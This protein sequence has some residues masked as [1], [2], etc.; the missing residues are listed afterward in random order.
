[1]KKQR[2]KGNTLRIAIDGVLAAMC[3]VLGYFALDLGSFKFTFENLPIII[4]ALLFGPVDGM[5]IGG[6]GTFVY[7]L[8]RYGLE[9]STPLWVVPYILSGLFVGLM[10]MAGKYKLK[11]VVMGIVIIA[12]GVLVTLLNS[13]SLVIWRVMGGSELQAAIMATL[14]GLPK[15]LL[16][17]FL[18][19]VVYA[20]F[21][22]ALIM[23]IKKIPALR[24]LRKQDEKP[25]TAK[26]TEVTEE[27]RT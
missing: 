13:V 23:V 9:F 8:V 24:D 15:R 18:K 2:L 10:S 1:M 20:L 25:K 5:L 6:V 3:A 21:M 16:I 26:E 11:P 4:G 12:D 27:P 7:Q 14:T 19:T 17:G 22:P